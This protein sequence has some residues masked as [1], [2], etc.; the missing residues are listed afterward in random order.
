MCPHTKGVRYSISGCN[1][2]EGTDFLLLTIVLT[3][4]F[5]FMHKL[6]GYI[7]SSVCSPSVCGSKN[8]I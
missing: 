2:G 1:K 8:V 6:K 5:I 7:L 4:K 3:A